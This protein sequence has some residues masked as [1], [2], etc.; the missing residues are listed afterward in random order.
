MCDVIKLR[1]RRRIATRIGK[2]NQPLNIKTA[3][4]RQI[5]KLGLPNFRWSYYI[6]LLLVVSLPFRRIFIMSHMTLPE[7]LIIAAPL[8]L[9]SYSCYYKIYLFTYHLIK[10]LC[11]FIYLLMH[12][13]WQTH[14]SLRMKP[15]LKVQSTNFINFFEF[16]AYFINKL[17]NLLYK[18]VIFCKA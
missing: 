3:V 9:H 15:C 6:S 5:L 4:D 14:N 1:L 7:I 10:I 13:G 2:G 18:I 17:F 11:C 12:K 8:Q 16:F